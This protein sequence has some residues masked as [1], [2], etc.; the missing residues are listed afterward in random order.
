MPDYKNPRAKALQ[1]EAR[2][3]YEKADRALTEDEKTVLRAR[4]GAKEREAERLENA[5][6]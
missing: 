1:D 3:L 4:A 6:R 2:E 5:N